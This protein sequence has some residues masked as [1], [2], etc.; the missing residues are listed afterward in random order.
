MQSKIIINRAK[1]DL[2][3]REDFTLDI[4]EILVSDYFEYKIEYP[5]EYKHL[6][7]YMEVNGKYEASVRSVILDGNGVK[8]GNIKFKGHFL[9]HSILFSCYNPI[10]FYITLSGNLLEEINSRGQD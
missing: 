10:E 1:I 4:G 6:G 8:E 5:V 9:P 7:L 3:K 2:L